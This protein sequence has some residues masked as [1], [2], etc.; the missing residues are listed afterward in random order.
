[1]VVYRYAFLMFVLV[2]VSLDTGV[3]PSVLLRK[4]CGPYS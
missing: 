3:K 1:M 2:V 4:L